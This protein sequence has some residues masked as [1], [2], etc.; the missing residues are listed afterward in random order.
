LQRVAARD[1]GTPRI[2]ITHFP[3]LFDPVKIRL[4]GY[5]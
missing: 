5:S 3:N 4:N 1:N 2:E